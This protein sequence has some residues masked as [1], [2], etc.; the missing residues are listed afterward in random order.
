MSLK[1]M[2]LGNELSFARQSTDNF[3]LITGTGAVT[4]GSI[5]V[6]GTGTN[7]TT[8]LAVGGII[9]IGGQRVTIATIPSGTSLTMTYAWSNAS[10]SGLPIWENVNNSIDF[11]TKPAT[12]IAWGTL[13]DIEDCNINPSRTEEEVYSPNPGKYVL[14]AIFAKTVALKFEITLQDVSELFYELLTSSQGPIAGSGAYQPYSGEGVIT[15][16]FRFRQFSQNAAMVNTSE[17]WGRAICDATRFG[18]EV[19]KG[20][21]TFSCLANPHNSGVLALAIG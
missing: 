12:E 8:D 10:A 15:G 2:I 20:K 9:S 21:M 13:G 4:N 3:V 14:S 18:N 7:F 16:W 5:T 6:T 17:I 11:D 1:K 19:V